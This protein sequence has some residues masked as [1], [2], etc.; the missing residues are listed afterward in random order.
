MTHNQPPKTK[1]TQHLLVKVIDTN[2]T[3]NQD[4]DPWMVIALKGKPG[5]ETA[6]VLIYG[7]S[8]NV[9]KSYQQGFNRRM[10]DNAKTRVRAVSCRCH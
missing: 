2:E 8:E 5:R 7:V 4:D 9:A 3:N 10:K 1:Y 6:N